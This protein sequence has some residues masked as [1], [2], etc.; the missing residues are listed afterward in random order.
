MT[1]TQN[2]SAPLVVVV[3]AAGTQGGS[4]IK[5]LAESDKA[6]RLRGLTRDPTKPSSLQWANQ[7]VE[8]LGVT[9]TVENESEVLKSFEGANIVFV[10]DQCL[11]FPVRI[12]HLRFR[13]AMTNF[14][15]H[16]VKQRVR[17][18]RFTCP[19]KSNLLNK[20]G[21]RRGHIARQKRKGGRCRSS[22]MVGT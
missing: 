1:I 10:S 6:Y 21:D 12:A 14:W 7:G 4:V 5:A 18:L 11:C 22:R 8:M 16:M 20:T 3:G 13:K 19:S 15:A 2:T 17:L 9:P